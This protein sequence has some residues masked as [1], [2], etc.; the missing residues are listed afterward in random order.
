MMEWEYSK[1]LHAME[2]R[3][4][5]DWMDHLSIDFPHSFGSRKQVRILLFFLDDMLINHKLP[6]SS[7]PGFPLSPAVP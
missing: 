4:S 3:V 2:T 7:S 6:S 1:L 5:S